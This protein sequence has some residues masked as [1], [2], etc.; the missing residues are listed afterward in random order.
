MCPASRTPLGWGA[1]GAGSGNCG[2]RAQAADKQEIPDVFKMTL[3]FTDSTLQRS[4]GSS[5]E[6]VEN[7]VASSKNSS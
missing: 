6:Q 4:S 7:P 5:S 2:L 1:G 3:W